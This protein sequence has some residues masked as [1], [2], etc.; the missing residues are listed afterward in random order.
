MPCKKKE[1]HDCKECTC[2]EKRNVRKKTGFKGKIDQKSWDRLSRLGIIKA[3]TTAEGSPTVVESLVNVAN[4]V[5]S[6]EP[7]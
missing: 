6:G 4:K 1:C 3:L 5:L 2:S 7:L